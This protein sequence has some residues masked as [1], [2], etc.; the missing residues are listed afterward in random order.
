[1]NK[2]I[3]RCDNIRHMLF[4]VFECDV[5]TPCI[6]RTFSDFLECPLFTG[7]TVYIQILMKW[8]NGYVIC[9]Y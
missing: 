2:N 4:H 7:L 3:I 8:N 5:E 1:M 6:K 9:L